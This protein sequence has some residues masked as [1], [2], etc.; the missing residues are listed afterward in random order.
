MREFPAPSP[1][2][3]EILA[4]HG[5]WRSERTA[6]V[7]GDERKSWREFVADNHRFAHGLLGAGVQ[8]GDRVGVFMGNA[9]SM[10]TALFGTLASGA[11]SVPLNTSVADDAIVAMLGDAD[12]R[13][14][15]VSEEHRARF[16]RLLPRLPGDLV[17]ITDAV[18]TDVDAPV[19][20]TIDRIS[21]KQ[22]DTLPA[23]PLA[24]DSPLNIIYSSGTTGLPKGIL[25][26]HGGRRDWAYDLS[27]ALRYHGG[28]RT[29]LTIGLYS[30]I[31]WVAMLCTLLAGG[32]LVVH[33]RFDAAAFL[34]TVESEGITHTAMVPI[35]FQRVLEAQV[36]SPH[37]LSSM[38][39]MMS[40][41]SP[42]HEGLKRAI[43]ETFPCG[44]IELY[45]LTEGIITTL[46]PEDAEGR[47]SSVGKPL[48][49]T[50]ILIVGE[51]DKPC[52]DGE[53]GE[54][55]SRGRITM[56]GYWQREDANAD[57]RYVDGHGQVWLRS[58]DI[59]HLDAQ[60]F[61]Y[62]VDRKKDM[63]LSGGQN[64]YPQDIEALLVTHE[65]IA[66][67]AVIGA[68]SER[69]GET[70][71]ALVVVRDDSLTM[72]ALLEWANQRLGKQQR[73]ADCI[74]VEELPRNPNGKILKRELRKHYGDKRY[75]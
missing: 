38:H 9:Y 30:N 5:R 64:I 1:L 75:G 74:A 22:P 19:W 60:G 20:Q 42:L 31:S 16:D 49:G 59:G 65:G 53:A 11:V 71:I 28:A 29:L 48:V 35:Q 33:P 63:I 36:A 6:V 15:I 7:S 8:P 45:G 37:D 52:A 4:L 69:W 24:H 57:A 41:G 50:D 40:C 73:L 34:K 23:V 72:A 21:A 39:A 70:P 17:C 18:T 2:L 32:T 3:P 61:L 68:S 58:G 47:W 67:V 26:S 25:H 66:D 27:I 13:A 56:P 54:V 44:I 12:I 62:I 46:D 10:L 14:L 51:D 55:V 43:F